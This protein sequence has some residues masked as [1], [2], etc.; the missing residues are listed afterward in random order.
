MSDRHQSLWRRLEDSILR[1]EARASAAERQAVS[2]GRALRAE[3]QALV[4][5]I[6]HHAYR[7]TDEEFA[8]LLSSYSQDQMF[9]L[10]VATAYGA[11]HERLRAGLRAL[12][13]A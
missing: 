10:V 2:V 5:K 7:I 1:S 8:A 13:E 6:R 9:E 4:D 12:E 3:L 11:A